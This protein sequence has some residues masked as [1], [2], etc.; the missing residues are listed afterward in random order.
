VLNLD[1]QGRTLLAKLQAGLPVE[2]GEHV[3][4]LAS[5]LQQWQQ[6]RPLSAKEAGAIASLRIE[7]LA[8]YWDTDRDKEL[9]AELR[10]ATEEGYELSPRS[11]THAA[12]C[13]ASWYQGLT[14][15][16]TLE[17]AAKLLD[18]AAEARKRR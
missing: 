8:M 4:P 13:V 17:L 14:D 7:L 2:K 11:L 6:T 15:D 10:E 18:V 3:Q 1:D 16:K 12:Y 9:L 5:E